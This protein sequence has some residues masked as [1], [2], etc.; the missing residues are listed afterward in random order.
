MFPVSGKIGSLS[1]IRTTAYVGSYNFTTM[2]LVNTSIATSQIPVALDTIDSFKTPGNSLLLESGVVNTC[3]FNDTFGCS[4]ITYLNGTV[5]FRVTNK[6]AT[7]VTLNSADCSIIGTIFPTPILNVT[8]GSM[9]SASVSA[10][11][12]SVTGRLSGFLLG[13]GLKLA[14]NYTAANGMTQNALGNAFIVFG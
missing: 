4:N 7:P 8:L 9:Q 10:Q 2:S 11:C 6:L 14:M 13:Q 3:S 12:Y 1:L 5:S